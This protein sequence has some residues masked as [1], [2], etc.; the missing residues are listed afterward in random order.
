MPQ[1][2]ISDRLVHGTWQG[3]VYIKVASTVTGS[4]MHLE[5][6]RKGDSNPGCAI[7]QSK[8]IVRCHNNSLDITFERVFLE[9]H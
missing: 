7:N 3:V 2:N 8:I 1:I 5:C 4:R 6:G 9:H